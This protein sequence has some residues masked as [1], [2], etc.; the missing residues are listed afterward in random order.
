M[1]RVRMPV[2]HPSRMS[3]RLA[4]SVI[5]RAEPSSRR[6][7]RSALRRQPNPLERLRR[8]S[9]P[10]II[11][12]TVQSPHRDDRRFPQ[13]IRQRLRRSISRSIS[14][15]VIGRRQKASQA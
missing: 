5:P 15:S 4:K 11:G 6:L 3:S 10:S 9:D 1:K 8:A 13:G 2:E 7:L 14:D 12:A